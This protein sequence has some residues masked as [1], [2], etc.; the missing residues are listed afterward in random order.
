MRAAMKQE[1]ERENEVTA[2]AVLVANPMPK[3]SVEQILAV[4]FR[5]PWSRWRIARIEE[6]AGQ[7]ASHLFCSFLVPARKKAEMAI[8]DDELYK[9]ETHTDLTEAFS[10]G[11]C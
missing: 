10:A 3:W 1:R 2:C 4:H 5:M 11:V 6:D 7:P 9:M 8:S